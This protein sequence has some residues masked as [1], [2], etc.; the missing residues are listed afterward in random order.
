M[1]IHLIKKKIKTLLDKIIIKNKI[2]KL[3]K[4]KVKIN[5]NNKWNRKKM[6]N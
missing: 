5:N 4:V 2:Y 1:Q 6:M 3:L